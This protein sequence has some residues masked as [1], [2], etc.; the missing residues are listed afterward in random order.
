MLEEQR[1][2]IERHYEEKLESMRREMEIKNEHEKERL[3][4]ELEKFKISSSV[5]IPSVQVEDEG[6]PLG[7]PGVENDPYQVMKSIAFQPIDTSRQRT[8]SIRI[9]DI[10]GGGGGEVSAH[11]DASS[12]SPVQ[13]LRFSPS[14]TP[15]T[16][17][18]RH[19]LPFLSPATGQHNAVSTRMSESP[20]D[21]EMKKILET[22][23][24]VVNTNGIPSVTPPTPPVSMFDGVPD[25]TVSSEFDLG[26][27]S[28]NK[29]RRQMHGLSSS[30]PQGTSFPVEDDNTVDGLE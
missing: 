13:A 21:P 15:D 7:S 30:C 28:R 1:L 6:A 16:P 25:F 5:E 18:Q 9:K 27:R 19:E 20:I 24:I 22:Y 10:T 17:I 2:A 8:T 3:M 29:A 14:P 11:S 12:D 4:Q 23:E 26:P